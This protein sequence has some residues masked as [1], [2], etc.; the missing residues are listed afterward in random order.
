MCD[1]SK[2]LNGQRPRKMSGPQ[3]R[4]SRKPQNVLGCGWHPPF[5]VRFSPILTFSTFYQTYIFEGELRIPLTEWQSLMTIGCKGYEMF[6]S[7][8][9]RSNLFSPFLG[10]E[11]TKCWQKKPSVQLNHILTCLERTKKI[12]FAVFDKF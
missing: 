1:Q 11:N 3:G 7:S 8:S 12:V 5:P 4:V 9:M 10:K 6:I 2:S